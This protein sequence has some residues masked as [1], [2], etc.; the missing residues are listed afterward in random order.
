[1][2]ELGFKAVA[3]P[4]T[5]QFTSSNDGKHEFPAT[6]HW[7]PSGASNSLPQFFDWIPSLKFH[8]TYRTFE[9][10]VS[11]DFVPPHMIQVLCRDRWIHLSK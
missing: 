11:Q 7:K 4:Y 6:Q 10:K 9:S 1:M 5:S 3:A 2:F 8:A